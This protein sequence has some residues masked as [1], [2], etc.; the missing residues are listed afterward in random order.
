[1]DYVTVFDITK[2]GYR[3]CWPAFLG[4]PLALLCGVTLAL[5]RRLRVLVPLWIIAFVCMFSFAWT[6][7]S[8]LATVPRTHHLLFAA[9]HGHCEITEGV[10]TNFSAM[11]YE[12]HQDESFVVGDTYFC[13]SD[14]DVRPGFHK[15]QSHGGPIHE[16][17][18]VRILHLG[19]E[20][21]RLDIAK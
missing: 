10:V 2:E 7:S 21:A 17:L 13:Y 1:V 19:N 9:R 16:G 5:L 18:Q 20:I 12:G 14:Y 6:I 3:C 15:S 8:L 11:P 4:L